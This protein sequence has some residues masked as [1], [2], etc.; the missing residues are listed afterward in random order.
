MHASDVVRLGGV[1]CYEGGLAQCNSEHDAAAVTSL[2]R[3]VIECLKAC[4]AEGLLPRDE[5]M[6]T[7]GGSAVF[8]LVIPLLQVQGLT[9]SVRGVLRSGCYLTH[10]H[11]NYA[12]FL[13]QVEQREQLA[14]SLQPALCIW[15]MVQSVPEPGLALLTCGRR[16]ISY[17]QRMPIPVHHAPIGSLS[18]LPIP[19]DW[20]ITA[21]NDQH[22]YLR[23]DAAQATVKVGDRVGLGISHPCTTF[24]KWRWMA[25]ADSDWTVTG[26]I[27]TCF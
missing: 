8:D 14:S 10:D 11:G 21:L 15:T 9:P 27:S 18:T 24:D 22:A 5:V 23:F 6:V 3:R 19:S 25:L 13:K 12:G 4:D 17:D 26:A 7:A 20:A 16:D 2:V 1:E